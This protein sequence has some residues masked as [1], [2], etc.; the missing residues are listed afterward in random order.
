VIHGERFA[1]AIL[2]QINDP[3]VRHLAERPPTGGIDQ[4]SDNTDILENTPH[5]VTRRLFE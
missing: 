1:Q 4:I 5:T 2:A 3:E